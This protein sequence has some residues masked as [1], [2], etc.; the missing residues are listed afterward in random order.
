MSI[1]VAP[2]AL[3][4]RDTEQAIAD[5]ISAQT[6]M[7]AFFRFTPTMT[8]DETQPLVVFSFAVE[9]VTATGIYQMCQEWEVP[10]DDDD[11]TQ[12]ESALTIAAALSD[13]AVH[14]GTAIAT[15]IMADLGQLN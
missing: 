14:I 10:L 6:G 12:P 5:T 15:E 8:V 1:T 4:L 7:P 13:V 11:Y 3:Y 2:P 9:V